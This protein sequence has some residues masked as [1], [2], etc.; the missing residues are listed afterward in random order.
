MLFRSVSIG[1]DEVISAMLREDLRFQNEIPKIKGLLLG[2]G[3]THKVLI[4]YKGGGDIR[5]LR[6][7]K[8]RNRFNIL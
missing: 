5:H 2:M 8:L 1:I 4:Q 7:F 3:E 6:G